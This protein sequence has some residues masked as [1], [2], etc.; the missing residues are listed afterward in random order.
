M[1]LTD[2][3]T[4]EE[5]ESIL[6][7]KG[8]KLVYQERFTVPVRS[9][10]IWEKP[11]YPYQLRL[12]WPLGAGSTFE[13]ECEIARAMNRIE[14]ADWVEPLNALAEKALQRYH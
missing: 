14:D 9:F 1:G 10:E 2:L 3:R 13:T 8:W 6:K 11:G 12:E 4:R 5:C 7:A